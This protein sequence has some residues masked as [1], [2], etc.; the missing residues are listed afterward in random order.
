MYSVAKRAET[1]EYASERTTAWD[2][3]GSDS[4]PVGSRRLL[5]VCSRWICG[6]KRKGSERVKFRKRSECP[7]S[8]L[9]TPDSC[10]QMPTE[11]TVSTVADAGRGDPPDFQPGDSGSPDGAP[12]TRYRERPKSQ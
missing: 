7:D 12:R 6:E 3:T 1:G 11:N 10:F 5:T 9:Q 8:R 2:K 4:V